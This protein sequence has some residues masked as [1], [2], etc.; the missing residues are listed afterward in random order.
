MTMRKTEFLKIFY[1]DNALINL[2]IDLE[3]TLEDR[4]AYV[5][6]RFD[7]TLEAAV[8]WIY[9]TELG[10]G[11]IAV[12]LIGNQDL[13]LEEMDAVLSPL[14][15]INPNTEIH[16]GVAADEQIEAGHCHLDILEVK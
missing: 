8:Q 1:N 15:A 9:Q 12:Q 16:F 14:G 6:H 7:G 13:G 4:K 11:M 10:D 2:D 5:L 3:K